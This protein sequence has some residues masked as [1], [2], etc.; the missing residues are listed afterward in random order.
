MPTGTARQPGPAL[1]I[2][3]WAPAV[4][5]EESTSITI[6]H[7]ERPVRMHGADASGEALLSSGAIGADIIRLPPGAGFPPHTHPGHHMLIVIGGRG[8]ITY[9]GRV[10]PTSAGEVYIVE[11]AVSHAV[12]AITDHVILAVGAPHRPVE[13]RDRMTVVGYDEVLSPIGD[14]T[15]LIC[16]VSSRA[17]RYLHDAHCPHCPCHSCVAV[18]Q[19]AKA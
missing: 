3:R 6:A 11:G 13:S 12:G 18:A 14:M 1:A 7:G 10:H 15:C 19:E 16:G 17:P 8:T 5:D 2:V 9:D 4:I